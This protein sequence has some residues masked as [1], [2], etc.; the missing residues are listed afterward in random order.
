[1]EYESAT[2]QHQRV[3]RTV[4]LLRWVPSPATPTR[5]AMQVPV[6]W[7]LYAP[8]GRRVWFVT[9]GMESRAL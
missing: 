1:M 8:E 5:V 2:A 9:V 6:A 4:V 3:A 7:S